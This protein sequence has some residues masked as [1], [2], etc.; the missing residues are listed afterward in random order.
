ML[1]AGRWLKAAG[2]RRGAQR[3]RGQASSIR[4]SQPQKGLCGDRTS[5][6]Q[7]PLLAWLRMGLRLTPRTRA[8]TAL[9]AA[10]YS[11]QWRSCCMRSR[12]VAAKAERLTAGRG[13]FVRAGR[14]WTSR[15]RRRCTHVASVAWWLQAAC[16]FCYSAFL[17]RVLSEQAM[18][19]H[20][21]P[22]APTRIHRVVLELVEDDLAVG[23][24]KALHAV[25]LH[26]RGGSVSIS[27]AGPAKCPGQAGHGTARQGS[28]SHAT[29]RLGNRP[30]GQGGG[31]AGGQAG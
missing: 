30:G 29:W 16:A 10:L 24:H 15:I 11:L 12:S 4:H 7:A 28:R 9:A 17:L 31:Q 8:A 1:S 5:A 20:A 18:P 14:G 19:V 2:A 26:G 22:T 25:N 6:C 21:V 23:H 27:A 3:S 13:G